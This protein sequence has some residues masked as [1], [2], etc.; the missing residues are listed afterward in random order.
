MTEEQIRQ[1][2]IDYTFESSLTFEGEKNEIPLD[3]SLIEEGILDSF[4]IIELIG[5]IESTWRIEISS[6]DFTVEKMGSIHKMTKLI[7]KKVKSD[8]KMQ[9]MPAS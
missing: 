2:L 7:D 5:F 3:K 4:G 8:D 6:E 9:K 1:K